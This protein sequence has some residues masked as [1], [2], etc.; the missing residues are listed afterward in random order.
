MRNPA[1]LKHLRYF[2][3]GPAL[4]DTVIAAFRQKVMDCG[5]VTSGDIVPLGDEA[6]RLTRAHGLEPAQ[7]AEEFYKLA[8]ECGLDG[9]A[10]SIRDAVKASAGNT[11]KMKRWQ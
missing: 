5:M 8:L 11:R 3:Y 9:D 1:F 7:A 4:P 10:K 6:K 2:L